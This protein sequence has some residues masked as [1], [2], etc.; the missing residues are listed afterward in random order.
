MY[1]SLDEVKEQ[2]DVIVDF[3]VPATTPDILR[4]ALEKKIPAVIGTTGL[5]E[6]ELKLIRSAA[7][8][9]PVFQTGNMSLGVNLQLELVQL[10]AATLGANFDVEIIETHHRKKVDSPSGTALMLANAIASISPED[11]ELVIRAA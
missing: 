8:Q 4:Y 7:D 11:E 2:A 5:G 10:A 9:I 3:S 1:R 6:R